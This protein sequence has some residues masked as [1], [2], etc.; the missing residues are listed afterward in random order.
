MS[1]QSSSEDGASAV[2]TPTVL[3]MLEHGTERLEA[4]DCAPARRTAEWI[5][6]EVL[7][8][9]RAALYA[10]PNRP[11][12]PAAAQQYEAL[13]E[14]RA[15]GEP[16]QH[17]LGH[18]SFYGL[19]IQVSP[20]ALV[21]RP[22]TE[23]V[24]A[25]ALDALS[26]AEAPRILDVGTGSGCIA[27]A[28]KQERPD[29]L[30]Y[31]CDVSPDALAL[32]RTNREALG[33]DV[34]LLEADLRAEGVPAALPRALDLLVSNPPYIPDA[35]ADALPSTVREYDPALSLF[36]GKDPLR[37]YRPLVRWGTA[38]C[39]PGGAV[40]CEVHA[41]YADAVAALFRRGGRRGGLAAVTV[42]ADLSGRPRVVQGRR[43]RTR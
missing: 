34:Q 15:Q 13:V 22:E 9:S 25:Q 31:A 2:P 38:L 24:V 43:A 27:L 32:A 30:V 8:A 26:D 3:S 18:T 10:R 37:Y 28:L 29:A 23:T 1:A 12:S 40:V 35:E 36:A 4:A 41:E 16:L 19:R 6:A 21:P 39:R 11:V 20:A 14:R 5:L 42:E 7:E 17:V 33:L